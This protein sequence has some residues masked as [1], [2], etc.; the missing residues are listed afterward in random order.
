MYSENNVYLNRFTK[1]SY[2]KAC[3]LPFSSEIP[4]TVFL[5]HRGD[6]KPYWE[7]VLGAASGKLQVYNPVHLLMGRTDCMRSELVT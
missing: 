4:G 3:F 7:T 2:M 1:L 6:N 5:P